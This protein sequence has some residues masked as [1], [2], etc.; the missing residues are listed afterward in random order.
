MNWS[1][2]WITL[3]TCICT[4]SSGVV[5]L[6]MPTIICQILGTD[7]NV[8]A[9]CGIHNDSVGYSCLFIAFV[10]FVGMIISFFREK[11]ENVNNKK[12]KIN[13]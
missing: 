10:A 3:V 11:F 9:K 13:K 1:L 8:G 6:N 12:K 4:C 2:F 5:V 7:Y